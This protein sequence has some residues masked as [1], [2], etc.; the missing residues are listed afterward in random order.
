MGKLILI[1]YHMDLAIANLL[2]GELVL[3]PAPV[4]GWAGKEGRQRFCRVQTHGR[5]PCRGLTPPAIGGCLNF[6]NGH[7]IK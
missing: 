2:S 3:Q 1:P 5:P 6:G 4:C 7:P